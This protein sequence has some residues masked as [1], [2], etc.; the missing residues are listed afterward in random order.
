MCGTAPPAPRHRHRAALHHH[1]RTPAVDVVVVN[2]GD[3]AFVNDLLQS[4]L[5]GCETPR[6]LPTPESVVMDSLL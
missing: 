3:F 2:D 6:D 4:I 1:A 5:E